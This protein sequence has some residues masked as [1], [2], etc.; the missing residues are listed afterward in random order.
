MVGDGNAVGVSSEVIEDFFRAGK[1]FF[2]ADDPLF[3]PQLV[4][5]FGEAVFCRKSRRFP[6]EDQLSITVSFFQRVDK[7]DAEKT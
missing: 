6:R 4:D 2:G 1:R 5:Q 3:F 7:F